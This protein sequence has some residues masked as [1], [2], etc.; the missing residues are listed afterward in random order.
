MSNQFSGYGDLS[1]HPMIPAIDGLTG[2]HAT[3][4]LPL[5]TVIKDVVGNS[6][7]YIKANEGLTKGDAVTAVARAA[8]DS[9][10]VVDG[11]TTATAAI[12]H[13]DTNTSAWTINQYAGYYV[14]IATEATL[15]RAVQI[16]SHA[17]I[18]ASSEVDLNLNGITGEIF[19]D[20]DVLYIFNPYLMEQVDAIDEFIMGVVA[21]DI[22][23]TY[24]GW[25]QVGGYCPVVKAGHASTSAAIVVNEALV[26]GS[27]AA[28]AVQG[29][30]EG[31][32]N[33]IGLSPLVAIRALG[34]NT[35]GFTECYIKGLV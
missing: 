15:G 32:I 19:G 35:A 25:M 4:Q 24:F 30:T 28:G 10:T 12:L 14:S 26:P 8:W 33:E 29:V 16:K 9:T 18:G 17:A 23:S 34:A 22:T 31:E 7:R 27:D 1:G 6:F 21:G 20:G 2:N 11:A 13:V 5:G 3:Q